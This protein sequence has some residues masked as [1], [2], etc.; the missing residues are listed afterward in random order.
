MGVG[1][2]GNVDP[3]RCY[4]RIPTAGIRHMAEWRYGIQV[5]IELENR[6]WVRLLHSCVASLIR[7]GTPRENEPGARDSG[8]GFGFVFA[9]DLCEGFARGLG[10]VFA[11]ERCEGLG[12]GPWVRFR[13]ALVRGDS[14]AQVVLGFVCGGR[15]AEG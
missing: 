2:A 13:G 10:F 4:L 11:G 3:V 12:R 7:A 8:V 5:A 6:R 9:G 15:W 14:G 1:V